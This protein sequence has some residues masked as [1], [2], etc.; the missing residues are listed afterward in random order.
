M[1]R[2]GFLHCP[3][4]FMRIMH[5]LQDVHPDF[6]LIEISMALLGN[7]TADTGTLRASAHHPLA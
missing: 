4:H 1:Q 7:P 3:I 5:V 2:E 6:M